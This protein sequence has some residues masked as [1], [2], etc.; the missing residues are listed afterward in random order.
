VARSAPPAP[1]AWRSRI[2]RHGEAAPSELVPNPRNWRTHPSDQ[3]AAL[4]GALAE[5]GWVAEVT[6]NQTTGHVVD[7]HL[8]IDLALARN[9]PTVPVT[10]VEL[11]ED[12]ERLI[13][14]SLGVNLARSRLGSP[15]RRDPE[16]VFH[17]GEEL[18]RSFKGDF[19]PGLCLVRSVTA[20]LGQLRFHQRDQCGPY[21]SGRGRAKRN[22]AQFLDQP[23]WICVPPV[24]ASLG[25]R[26]P[27]TKLLEIDTEGH[28]LV[29]GVNSIARTNDVLPKS[30]PPEAPGSLDVG[31]QWRHHFRLAVGP[32]HEGDTEQGRGYRP[33]ALHLW[34]YVWCEGVDE[35]ERRFPI[36]PTFLEP[37]ARLP[38]CLISF[39]LA[40][41][42]GEKSEAIRPF[43][44]DEQGNRKEHL[45][46]AS[47]LLGW[48]ERTCVEGHPDRK[49][50]QKDP[51]CA[52]TPL[53]EN[54]PEA[55]R[56]AQQQEAIAQCSVGT[57][58][59]KGRHAQ[60]NDYQCQR[61]L[62][63]PAPLP[64]VHAL[65]LTGA[66]SDNDGPHRCLQGLL[67]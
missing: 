38:K 36:S 33:G 57:E 42:R 67:G 9:E 64:S 59:Q 7:G 41:E 20:I 27:G 58:H 16:L 54:E 34:K 55:E 65:I 39:F 29:P 4:S 22:Q 60:N 43:D 3:Q 46:N 47:A 45:Q 53:S 32:A 6:V 15:L 21:L 24:L 12:E 18:G 52:Q 11:S 1:P 23:G 35:I 25:L 44:D 50:D 13:L 30:G 26:D 8:R 62:E 63:Q 49:E 40:S 2:V 51:I 66:T 19:D 56:D 37:A 31:F 61:G 10:Y 14:A 17:G 5:V 28:R 48:D